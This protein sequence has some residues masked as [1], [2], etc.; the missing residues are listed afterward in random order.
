MQA[1][2][3]PPRSVPTPPV[4]GPDVR[5]WSTLLRRVRALAMS[6]TRPRGREALPVAIDSR[7]VYV[8]PTRFGLFYAALLAAM[9]VGALNYNNNPAL[10][11]GFLL[12]GAGLASLVAA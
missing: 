3:A 2:A 11:L 9:I 7:R 5:P 6:L 1:N 10:M 8:L 12:A 4:P